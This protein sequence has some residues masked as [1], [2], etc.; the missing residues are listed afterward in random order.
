MTLAVPSQVAA[1]SSAWRLA[2]SSRLISYRS[3]AESDPI[4]VEVLL[5]GKGPLVVLLPSLGRGASDFDDL[6][7]RIAAAGFQTAAINPRGIGASKGPAARTLADYARDTFE[8]IKA[9][10]GKHPIQPL[11]LIGHAFGNRLARAFASQYPESVS[12]LILL[13]SGGQVAIPPT[14]AKALF[15]VFDTSQSPEPHITAVRTAF[16]APGLAGTAREACAA[17]CR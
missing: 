17:C 6:S 10:E 3:D 7:T 13:A 1:T 8:V 12:S 15:D 11:V 14:V 4:T 2:A 16:F 5:R 9:V